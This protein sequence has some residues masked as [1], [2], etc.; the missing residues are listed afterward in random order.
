M[1]ALLLLLLIQEITQQANIYEKKHFKQN[2]ISTLNPPPPDFTLL[3]YNIEVYSR[4]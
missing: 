3:I 4:L 1:Y 2:E